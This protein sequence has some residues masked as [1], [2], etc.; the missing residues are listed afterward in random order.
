MHAKVIVEIRK[1]ENQKMEN[2]TVETNLT[3][4]QDTAHYQI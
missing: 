3:P 2:Q 4:L 1:T